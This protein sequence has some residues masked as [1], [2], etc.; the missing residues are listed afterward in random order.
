MF[1]VNKEAL[2]EAAKRLRE[3]PLDAWPW[4]YIEVTSDTIRATQFPATHLCAY[5][6]CPVKDNRRMHTWCVPLNAEADRLLAI[7]MDWD[8]D[9]PILADALSALHKQRQ[10]RAM[11]A[12]PLCEL[13]EWER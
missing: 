9:G 6:G 11:L 3:V 13:E 10:G 7:M 2:K 12:W 1:H 4:G 5:C 8:G